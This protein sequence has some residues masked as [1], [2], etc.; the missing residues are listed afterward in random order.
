[1]L[2]EDRKRR[3]RDTLGGELKSARQKEGMTQKALSSALGLE[4]YTMVSQ[5]ELGYISIPPSLWVPI[6]QVLKMPV[7][8]W[9]LRCL[10]EY[11]PEVFQAV[12]LNRSL[13]EAELTIDLLHK[14]QLDDLISASNRS[15]DLPSTE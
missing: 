4:Y 5:M 11:Q 15:I 8:N 10:R 1:M 12:F 13:R 3:N 2:S 14:G 7:P 9:V 6:A